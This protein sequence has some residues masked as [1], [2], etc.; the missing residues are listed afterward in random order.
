MS[1]TTYIPGKE[2][3]REPLIDSEFARTNPSTSDRY[4]FTLASSPDLLIRRG[5]KMP[6]NQAEDA[7]AQH[8]QYARGLVRLEEEY[9]I[10]NP[11]MSVSREVCPDGELQYY[12]AS[13][14]VRG[15]SFVDNLGDVPR[16]LAD[17]IFDKILRYYGDLAVKTGTYMKEVTLRQM[18]YGVLGGETE[19]KVYMVDFE[20]QSSTDFNGLADDAPRLLNA[21]E[22]LDKMM[23][24]S[25]SMMSSA[26]TGAVEPERWINRTKTIERAIDARAEELSQLV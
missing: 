21:S 13:N 16:A 22:W 5:E 10:Y 17:D 23:W 6:P 11:G 15:I 12:I 2:A 7:T 19:P 1:E 14:R 3:F 4:L 24:R 26:Y 20:T 8:E 18:V 25:L 9:G